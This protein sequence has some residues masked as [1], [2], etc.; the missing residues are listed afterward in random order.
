MGCRRGV[1]SAGR[2]SLSDQGGV[3]R[4]TSGEAI[5]VMIMEMHT[6]KLLEEPQEAYGDE[7]LNANWLPEP[8]LQLGLQAVAAETEH[9]PLGAAQDVEAFLYAVYRFQE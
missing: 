3:V 1:K 2:M 5:V 8:G 6:G 9:P 4:Q 7:V